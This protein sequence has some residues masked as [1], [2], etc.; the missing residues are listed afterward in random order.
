QA[1]EAG[2]PLMPPRSVTPGVAAD[3]LRDD[4]IDPTTAPPF[5]TRSDQWAAWVRALGGRSDAERAKLGDLTESPRVTL[6][7]ARALH[8]LHRELCGEG[9]TIG[10]AAE[11]TEHPALTIAA[12]AEIDYLADL[13]A[14][15]RRD[16]DRSRLDALERPATKGS[17]D[18]MVLAGI[19]DGP[20]ILRKL[21]L[22][23]GIPIETLVCSPAK[24]GDHFDELGWVRTEV[25][26]T[27]TLGITDDTIAIVR[28]GEH[29]ARTTRD[30]IA[31]VARSRPNASV[32]DFAV[33]VN[34]LNAAPSIERQLRGAG[35]PT[36]NGAGRS[37]AE[38]SPARLLAALHDLAADADYDAIA[39]LVRHPDVERWID[40]ELTPA[41]PAKSMPSNPEACLEALDEYR[42]RHLPAR[43]RGVEGLP[44]EVQ[45]LLR[46][47][48]P[49]FDQ[50]EVGADPPSRQP[51]AEHVATLRQL[52]QQLVSAQRLSADRRSD[53]EAQEAWTALRDTMDELEQIPTKIAPRSTVQETIHFLQ[54]LLSDQAISDA[55]REPAVELLGWLELTLDDAPNLFVTGVDEPGLPAP[56]AVDPFLPER[57]RRRLG[58][59]DHSRR[60]ARDAAV[61]VALANDTRDVH[62]ITAKV[63]SD[64]TQTLPSRILLSEEPDVI[65]ARLSRLEEDP[66]AAATLA[67][68]VL[69]VDNPFEIPRPCDSTPVLTSLSVT[70]FRNYI[71]CPYRF[72]L[73]RLQKIDAKDDLA[74]ELDAATFG[75]GVHDV[76]EE[77]GLD[78]AMRDEIRGDVIAVRLQALFRT[79]ARRQFGDSPLPA[80]RV[81]LLGAEQRLEAFAHWQAEWRKDG[82]RIAHV[83]LTNPD[84]GVPFDVDGEP[85]WLTGKIDRIDVHDSTG[86]IVIIDYKTSDGGK[87]P[88]SVHR[89]T[90]RTPVEQEDG[91]IKQVPVTAWAD[92]QLPLYRH[93]AAAHGLAPVGQIGYVNLPRNLSHVGFFGA[94]WGPEEFEE[95]DEVARDVVRGLRAKKFWPPAETPPP[96]SE[97]FSPICQDN[98]LIEG[99]DEVIN[100]LDPKPVLP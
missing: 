44:V 13:A 20:R 22:T 80:V 83:E 2:L 43:W 90:K 69:T 24:R 96:F 53:R 97:V 19:F 11:V 58:L 77:F 15:D 55:N 48:R 42:V 66:F 78:E 10:F 34:D 86:E 27:T 76:L 28:D 81:Q 49:L 72:Y 35:V 93:L 41:R 4:R 63:A 85:F 30:R 71:A 38:S 21:L 61:A 46:P 62:W 79:W 91:T 45:H 84:E 17:W 37:F 98:L 95:A 40:R 64:G 14:N 39:T 26:N 36:R 1:S 33:G 31:A 50:L 5:A 82:Y 99:S 8:S 87:H 25:W 68:M 59:L 67:P 16:P 70:G 29:Q 92:L 94:D 32:E 23:G 18:L 100:D 9:L 52:L 89:V 60:F 74:A 73:S 47:L 75:S 54:Q 51:I 12:A 57:L 6:G 3:L 56:P 88:D 65:A 7:V